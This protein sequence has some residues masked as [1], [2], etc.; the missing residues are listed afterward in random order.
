MEIDQL[1]MET[2]LKIIPLP[3]ARVHLIGC[4]VD[5]LSMEE[6]LVCVEKIIALREPVQHCVV[7]AGKLVLMQRDPLLKQIV[8]YCPL[9]N[10]DGQSVV[11]ALKLVGRPIPERVTGI[12]LME[13]LLIEADKKHYRIY[14]LGAEDSILKTLLAHVKKFFPGLVIAGAHHGYFS[15]N[16]NDRVVAD[17]ATSKADIIFVAMGSP[18]KEYWLAKNISRLNVPFCMGVG[19]SF[20]VV[21]GKAKRAPRWIQNIGMEW[22]YRFIQEPRRLW[23]R[24][25]VD[26]FIFIFL[27]F[28]DLLRINFPLARKTSEELA[29]KEIT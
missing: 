20:D 26:N 29:E 7:N 17:V 6:T 10:A 15:D 4:P 8:Q 3:R 12:D 23:R 24:Y 5:N 11:W 21:A 14:F 27:V 19:G 2:A 18:K 28:L 13:R 22:F 25:L 16:E 9:I 1:I